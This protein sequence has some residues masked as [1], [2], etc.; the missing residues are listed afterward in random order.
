VLGCKGNHAGSRAGV[1]INVSASEGP[2]RAASWHKLR[3]GGDGMAAL[4]DAEA[5]A[6]RG[7]DVQLRRDQLVIGPGQLQVLRAAGVVQK[8]N[9]ASKRAEKKS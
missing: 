1:W 6:G 5:V 4:A 9:G 3:P 7:E 2:G 8:A